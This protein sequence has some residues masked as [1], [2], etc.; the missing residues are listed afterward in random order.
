MLD[1]RQ[2]PDWRLTACALILATVPS[3]APGTNATTEARARTE[4]VCI[5]FQPITTSPRDTEK[6]LQQI[7]L[8]NAVWETACMGRARP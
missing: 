7:D 2:M 3:C 6:T 5:A 8:H 1:L 4:W